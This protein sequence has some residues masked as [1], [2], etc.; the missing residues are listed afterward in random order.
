[1][2]N[3]EISKN[4]QLSRDKFDEKMNSFVKNIPNHFFLFEVTKSC[5]GYSE[6]QVMYK[7]LTLEDLYK[8]VSLYI[9]TSKTIKLYLQENDESS[10]IPCTKE[11]T[12]Y[13]Y[14]VQIQKS[15]PIYNLDCPVVYRIYLDDGHF[16]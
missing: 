15:R 5:C 1:M 16:H 3:N 7:K 14:F 9:Q 8:N 13:E 12:I 6:F 2:D 11:Q 4:N 10:L